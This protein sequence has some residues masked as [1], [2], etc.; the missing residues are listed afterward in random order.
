[1]SYYFKHKKRTIQV[2]LVGLAMILLSFGF[3]V[4]QELTPTQSIDFC[5]VENKTF[6]SGETVVYKLYYNWNFIWLSAGE[7]VFR[8]KEYD[9]YYHLS[10][11]GRTYPSYEWFFKVR[12]YFES[13]VDKETLLPF[14]SVRDV[15][16]GN[17]S[18]YDKIEFD[19]QSR[20][21]KYYWGDHKEDQLDSGESEL[22]GCIHDIISIFYTLRNVGLERFKDGEIF[23][24]EVFM[25]KESWPLNVQVV[26]KEKGKRIKGYGKV[27]T[28]QLIPGLIEGNIF[29]KGD[30][31]NVYVSNDGNRVPLMIE[32]PVSVGSIKAIIKTWYGLK[33]PLYLEKPNASR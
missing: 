14:Y 23:P 20:R 28:T 10:A 18:R 21:A 26:S 12:D 32:T 7:V 22:D 29:K 25:D 27:E 17:Y 3:A 11:T 31:M 16:E 4:N 33:E 24:V 13:R 2:L 15:K 9:D 6:E 8:V 19:Q 30:E 5:E 1:M